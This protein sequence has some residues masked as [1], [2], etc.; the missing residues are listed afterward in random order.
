MLNGLSKEASGVLVVKILLCQPIA[1]NFVHHAHVATR[2][3][4]KDRRSLPPHNPRGSSRKNHHELCNRMCIG[5]RGLF[6]PSAI[7]LEV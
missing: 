1:C 4:N 7:E 6:L 5:D 2:V 3:A